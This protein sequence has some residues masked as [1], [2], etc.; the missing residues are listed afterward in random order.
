M[1]IPVSQS[2][3]WRMSRTEDVPVQDWVKLAVNRARITGYPAV[4][5]LDKNRAH[6]AQ[7]IKKVEKFLKDHDTSGLDIRI[8]SP[9][10]AMQFTLETEY[11]KEKIP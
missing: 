2:D 3:I 10:D 1:T 6:D 7:L 5:W 8:M 11:V 4:F 9:Q